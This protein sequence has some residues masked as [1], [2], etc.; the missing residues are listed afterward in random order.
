MN[1]QA[2]S[3]L[4]RDEMDKVGLKDWAIRLTQHTGV[5]GMCSYKDKTIIFS[6]FHF[7]THPEPEILNTIRHESAHALCPGEGHNKVWEDKARELGCTSVGPCSHLSYSPEIIDAIRSGATIEVSYTTEVIHKPHYQI[8]RLQDKCDVCGKVAKTKSESL[9]IVKDDTKPDRKFIVLECGHTLIRFIPKGTPFHKAVTNFWKPD[10][11]SCEHEWDKNQCN[12][13]GEFR[14]FQFQVDGARFVE[15]GLSV[16]KGAGVFDE[17]GLGK[18]IQSLIYLKYH[19][20]NTPALFIVK[21]K[22]KFQWFREIRRWCGPMW[23]PQVISSSNDW[24]IPGLKAYIISYDMLVAKDR[25]GKNGKTISQGFDGSKFK[26][27]GIKTVILDECQQI[28][29]P[30]ATR[31]QEV[32][33]ICADCKVI[34]LSGTPWKNRGDEFFV[35]L[36]MLDPMKFW[37]HQGFIDKWVDT[38]FDGKYTKRGGIR[39]VKEFREATKDLFIRR[40]VEEV[41]KE[42][43]STNRMILYTD[44]EAVEQINYDNEVSAFVKWYNDAQANDELNSFEDGGNI[45]AKLTRMRHITGL[46]K[47]PATV[48]FI[49]DTTIEKSKKICVFVHHKDVGEIL[50]RTCVEELKGDN[51]PVFKLTADM[52]P[53]VISNTIDEFNKTP[54]CAMVAS[55]L[56]CGEG[57]NLQTCGDAVMHERQWNPQNEDQAAPGRF[58]RIGSKFNIVNVTFTTASDTID[59]IMAGIVERKRVAFHNAMNKGEMPP[60]FRQSDFAREIADGIVDGFNKKNRK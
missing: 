7:D 53:Q 37:S 38:Y 25:K 57:I 9:V 12:K 18:T 50:Y 2:A 21:S 47:I 45:L 13:C 31:T 40:E 20:E 36:N 32:R 14:P 24:L 43:P 41:M 16:N 22:L 33:K 5:L 30:D 44:L 29:N 55:T 42:M 34:P 58:R 17:M 19:E 15:A 48:E 35:V 46:A 52:N 23:T 4:A 27:L 49:A 54:V 8:T 39:N 26:E 60:V 10:V 56:A 11:E 51:I 1:R 3:R 59:E 28:K 6:T